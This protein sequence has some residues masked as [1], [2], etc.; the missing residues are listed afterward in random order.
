MTDR[1]AMIVRTF[2]P[3]MEQAGFRQVGREPADELELDDGER[4]ALIDT[5]IR[6]LMMRTGREAP[7]LPIGIDD[8]PADRLEWFGIAVQTCAEAG[9]YYER[10]A[11]AKR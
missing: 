5:L 11:Q 10:A 2:T 6:R 9:Y 1:V 3:I 8:A 4:L 7:A